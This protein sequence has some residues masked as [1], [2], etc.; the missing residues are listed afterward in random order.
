MII[1]LTGGIGS[2]KSAAGIEFEK[3]GITVIDA[4]EIAQ[5]ASLKN[6]KA[7]KEIVEYFGASILDNSQNIDRRKLRNIVFNN[8]EQ[9]KKLEQILHP[10]IREDIS[11]A[12]SNSKSPYT[13]IMVPLIYE[14][15]SKDNYNRI[16]VIDCDE[17]I[18]ISRAVTRDGASEEDIKKIINSQATK[19][20]RLSIAD[21]VISNNSS[22]EKL[23]DKVLHLHKNYLELING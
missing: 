22:I 17:D 12:I 19:K 20:E 23:S 8:D 10:A 13:I 14:T 1:G 3:L 21:D 6:S 7:Y 15:N 4:D 11:F 2:G 5:K 16:L 9:K 18:Q